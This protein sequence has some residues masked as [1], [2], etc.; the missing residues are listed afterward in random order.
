[1]TVRGI[2]WDTTALPT[3][4]GPKSEDGSGTGTYTSSLIG[5]SAATRYYV[6]AYATNIA[7]TGYGDVFSFTTPAQAPDTTVV[8]AWDGTGDYTTVQ[9]A[10][11]AVPLLYTGRWTIFVKKGTYHEK[12]TLQAYKPN[13]ELVGE[14]RDS[15]VIWNDDYGDKYGSGNPGTSGSFTVT[16]EAN[17]FVAR[18]ITIQNTY[19][20]QSGVSGTQAVA[21]RVNGDRQEYINCR[22]RGYQD[23]YY[24]WGGSGTG[25]TYH[26]N[27]HI[28]GTVDFIFG[29]N[30]V[31]FDSCTI[32]V[33]RNGGTLTAASTDA[34][35]EFGYVLRNCTI[36]ADTIGYDGNAIASFYLG[37]PWQS[38][39]RTV[40][41]QTVE[42]WNLHPAGWLAWN[43]TP[44]LYAEYNCTGPGSATGGRVAW[45]SQLPGSEVSKYSLS[46]IFARSS[47][48]SSLITYDW[49]PT[50][51]TPADDFPIVLGVE[52]ESSVLDVPRRLTLVNHPNPFNPETTVRFSVAADGRAVVRV[53]TILGQQVGILYD[54]EAHAGRFYEARFGS[55]KLSTGVYYCIIESNH[56]RQVHRMLLI[57]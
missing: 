38:S 16:I 6:R 13:V 1:V 28:E 53:L 4:A 55:G 47:A 30:I 20:P 27:C 5:L 40:I 22:L 41:I 9:A 10:F 15:T 48:V 14:D 50:S 34:T 19:A 8:V 26:K 12:D 43:V 45:S 52:R 42:P 3:T 23:T 56:Q 39:P 49:Y 29:R 21:L 18:N 7:G 37:R 36:V 17:D 33:L 35:S 51:A 11:N 25:R 54:D 32:R 46:N 24:T 31:V 57:K 44:A 2:C